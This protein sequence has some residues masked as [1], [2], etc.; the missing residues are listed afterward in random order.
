MNIPD[1]FAR[2][3]RV[4]QR[5]G[6]LFLFKRIFITGLIEAKNA[7]AQ[8]YYN[9]FREKRFFFLG[10]EY[11][12]FYHRY[13]TTWKNERSYEIPLMEKFVKDYAGKRILEIGNVLNHYAPF[14]HDVVD[15]YEIGSGIINEDI[16]SFTPREPYELIVS[17]STIEHIGNDYGEKK[18]DKK[19]LTALNHV[20]SACLARGGL[21]A[22][23][24]SLGHN[25]SFD[26]HAKG[27]QLPFQKIYFWK[28]DSFS[29]SW[30]ETSPEEATREKSPG[31]L[32][33]VDA[34]ILGLYEN[35]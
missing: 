30:R 16:V 20:I 12:A 17:V 21:F 6:A 28:Y 31:R 23:T 35:N 5:G 15:K 14:K 27:D 26:A 18:E 3:K 9:L 29:D 25:R 11:G 33:A 13:N 7:V 8:I 32:A 22:A 34:F 24:A 4:R 2:V 1:F 19:V 10:Q